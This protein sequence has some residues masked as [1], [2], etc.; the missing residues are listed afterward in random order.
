MQGRSTAGGLV[1][2]SSIVLIISLLLE[3]D[4]LTLISRQQIRREQ[5]QGLVTTLP[6]D[7]SS[8][9]RPIGLTTRHNWRPTATQI[10]FIELLK[11]SAQRHST[12]G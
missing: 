7:M 4:R 11:E 12:T 3:S 8:T 6:F 10:R 5:A 1:E 9:R 2:S